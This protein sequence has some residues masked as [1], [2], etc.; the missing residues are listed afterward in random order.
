MK[1]EIIKQLGKTKLNQAMDL[2]IANIGDSHPKVRRAIVDAL[3]NHK[4]VASYDALK[5]IIL[6][7]DASYY[8]EASAISGITKIIIGSLEDKQ[9]ETIELLNNVLETKSGWNEVLRSAAIN[10]LSKLKTSAEAVD[11]IVKYTRVG[12]PQALRLTSIRGLGAISAGQ[13][14]DKLTTIL[15]KFDAM[16]SETFFLTQ[17]SLIGGLSQIKDARAIGL[18]GTLSDTT[19]DGRVKQ[20]AEEAMG[21]VRAKLDKSDNLES[22]QKAIDKLKQENQDLQS[23]LAKL[24]NQK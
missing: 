15:E 1:V 12:T 13:K 2:L 18:L 22:L 14:A 8:V 11:I 20:R 4:N 5:E 16:I 6:Q 24:E 3:T 9:S 17:I 23:R 19:P 7:G 21:K 10:G